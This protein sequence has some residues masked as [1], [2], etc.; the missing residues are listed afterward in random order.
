M[1]CRYRMLA[2]DLDGTLLNAR[3]IVSPVNAA[4]VHRARAAG[5]RVT[6]CT[7]RGLVEAQP[8]LESI[9]QTEPV[10]VA[11]GAVTADPISGATL[12]RDTMDPALVHEVVGCVHE[13]GHAA[14]VL[15]DRA[16]A[17]FDYLV[18]TAGGRHKPDPV[19]EWWFE[20]MGVSVREAAS[21]DEDRHPGHTVRVGAV[22]G[23]EEV[24]DTERFLRARFDGRVVL[25]TFSI[26]LGPERTGSDE[27][28]V[29][30]LE[31]F[32]PGSGK[33]PAVQ[34]LAE[35]HGIAPAEIAA[36][37]DETNDL[38]MIR[39]AGLGVAM[40]NAVTPVLNAADRVT[41]HHDE[42]GVAAAID[43]IIAG[44]W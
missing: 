2:L 4:A 15:K 12:R 36:I 24:T 16:E 19:T 11:G 37:G 20:K 35:G 5:L 21:I 23:V 10:V 3:G 40:R 9:A 32:D 38:E 43:K 1:A 7:G 42:D 29:M 44:E 18:V 17:G 22:G 39:G 34:R 26:M 25:Q 6:V 41:G 30:I 14:L 27:R 31:A 33:W 13:T 8:H 28:R